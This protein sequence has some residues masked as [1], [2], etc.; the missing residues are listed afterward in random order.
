ME[1]ALKYLKTIFVKKAAALAVYLLIEA[2]DLRLG[3]KHSVAASNPEPKPSSTET[4]RAPV[5][6]SAKSAE[7]EVPV[8]DG[9]HEAEKPK[10]TRKGFM[11]DL[12]EVPE[13]DTSNVQKDELGKYLNL[14]EKKKSEVEGRIDL[15]EE[16]E[17]KLMGIEKSIDQKL[18]R[19]EEER[20]FFLDTLQKEKQADE[21]RTANL[22]DFYKKMNPKTAA[23]LF[24]KMDRDLAVHLFNKLPQK[25]IT[26]ILSLMTPEVAVKLTEYYGRIR[27]GKEYELLKEIN[28][29]LTDE[30]SKCKGM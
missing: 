5:I 1:R 2:F 26:T 13:L 20:R 11:D 7:E 8:D 28:K 23:P 14:A 25:Q 12:F 29:S 22:V 19:L 27:S 9:Y 4:S 6:S 24:E 30:F 3:E 17:K 16:R 15:L 21:E 18:S 10:A